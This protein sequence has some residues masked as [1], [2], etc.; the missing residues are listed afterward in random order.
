MTDIIA[1]EK[2]EGEGAMSLYRRFTK[3]FRSS[4]IQPFVKQHRFRDRKVSK[5][6]RKKNKMNK[7]ARSEKYELAYRLGKISTFRRK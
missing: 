6:I 3:Q 5:S 4:G 1:M 2:K 7:I